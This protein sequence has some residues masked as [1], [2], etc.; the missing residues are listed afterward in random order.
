MLV[1]QESFEIIPIY[2]S[3]SS[4]VDW[5]LHM[6]L[7]KG[8]S[9]INKTLWSKYDRLQIPENTTSICETCE[10]HLMSS[11]TGDDPC[12]ICGGNGKIFLK[13][14]VFLNKLKN[15]FSAHIAVLTDK[16][17]IF[18]VFTEFFNIV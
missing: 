15:L 11:P 1:G 10:G 13:V 9:Y 16:S 8:D 17:V 6:V 18:T 2:Q 7:V 12:V 4:T 14:G 3:A 5:S